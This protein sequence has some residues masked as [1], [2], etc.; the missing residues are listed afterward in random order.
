MPR[1]FFHFR[2]GPHHLRDRDGSELSDDRA[3]R[4]HAGREIRRILEAEF[5]KKLRRAECAVTVVSMHYREI[6]QIPFTHPA[7]WLYGCDLQDPRLDVLFRAHDL[8]AA[9]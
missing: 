5:G 6:F 9:A 2:L 4:D 3:A 1:Y 7:A 8:N